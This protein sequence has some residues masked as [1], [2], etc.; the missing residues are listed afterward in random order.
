VE[1]RVTRTNRKLFTALAAQDIMVTNQRMP[2]IFYDDPDLAPT[3]LITDI[4]L[5][6]RGS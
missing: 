6:L 4:H 1:K 3:E 5:P 2:A